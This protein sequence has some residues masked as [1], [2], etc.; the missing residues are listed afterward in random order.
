[1]VE[2]QNPAQFKAMVEESQAELRAR[3]EV[4]QRLAASPKQQETVKS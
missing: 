1:M 2:Q 3:W 4:L